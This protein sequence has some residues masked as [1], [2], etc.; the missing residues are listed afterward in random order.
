MRSNV[1][2]R[3]GEAM[4]GDFPFE[5][6]ASANRFDYPA[7]AL[8][9]LRL[10]GSAA[11]AY[12]VRAYTT[13]VWAG[14]RPALTLQVPCAGYRID[15][16]VRDDR[17]ALAIEIDGM[18]FHHRSREQVADDYLRERR[19]VAKGYTVI[20]FTAQEAFRDAEECWRQVAVILA[21]RGTG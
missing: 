7:D 6:W 1:L 2:V 17:G 9:L 8:S 5:S 19:I 14:P 13:R 3:L 4:R 11:E 10:C 20:R 16:V 21:A 15:C 18:G 12:F